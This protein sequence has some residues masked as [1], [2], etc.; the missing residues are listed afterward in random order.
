[1]YLQFC[2]IVIILWHVLLVHKKW[3]GERERIVCL[4]K[5]GREVTLHFRYCLS[6]TFTQNICGGLSL[7]LCFVCVRV[8]NSDFRD[9]PTDFQREKLF[10]KAKKKNIYLRC[11]PVHANFGALCSKIG[12]ITD[13]LTDCH[14]DMIFFSQ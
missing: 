13:H 8:E 7:S 1:M 6:V 9:R 2:L 3:R 10:F 11:D 14:I 12:I 5:K 4:G